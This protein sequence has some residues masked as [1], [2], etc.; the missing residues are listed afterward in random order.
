MRFC[1]I[2]FLINSIV[3]YSHTIL[4]KEYD[5]SF[6]LRASKLTKKTATNTPS[7]RPSS[8]S[9][10]IGMQASLLPDFLEG[11]AELVYG[12]F[13]ED[14][15]SGILDWSK[16]LGTLGVKGKW[17]AL[18]Y[19]FDFYSVGQQYQGIFSSKYTHKRGRT[20]YDS[21][22]SLNIEKLKIKGKYLKSWTNNTGNINLIQSFD[23][24]YQVETSYP[25]TSRPLTELALTYGLGNRRNY[26][27][28]NHL[29]IYQ[30]SLNLFKTNFRFVDDYLSF[31]TEAKQTSS[32][33]DIGNKIDFQRETFFFTSTLFPQHY[34]SIISSYRYTID[35]Y[36]STLNKYKLKRMESSLGLIYKPTT[37]PANLK[38]TSGYRTYQSDNNLTDKEIVNFG[39]QLNWKSTGSYTGL[40]T[41]WMVNFRYID[42]TD[43]INPTNN[44]SDLGFNLSCQWPLS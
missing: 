43:Y 15:N 38:L 20:G 3:L 30:G 32:K 5:F 9:W 8:K 26:I 12:N 22:L 21:W 33:N 13:G 40:K 1:L 16:Y 7:P 44:Y 37:L 34:F 28:S 10:R 39:A 25:L 35:S 17:G 27:T 36:I 18:G 2:I 23:N 41:D 24:W 29:P 6:D 19:G 4:A 42:T 14:S 11:S 31:S